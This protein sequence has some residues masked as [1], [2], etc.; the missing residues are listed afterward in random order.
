M[1]PWLW[2]KP[3]AAAPI[4]PLAQEFL[5]ATVQPQKEK[6]KKKKILKGSYTMIEWDLSQGWFGICKSTQ[7]YGSTILKNKLIEK[8]ITCVVTRSRGVGM[9]KMY[10]GDQKVQTSSYKY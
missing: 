5:Y 8:E 9:G 6:K 1:W 4:P 3:A 2:S 10:E 7:C